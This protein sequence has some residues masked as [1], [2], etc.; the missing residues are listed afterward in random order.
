MKESSVLLRALKNEQARIETYEAIKEIRKH[1]GTDMILKLAG[2]ILTAPDDDDDDD[3]E[4]ET[5]DTNPPKKS[6]GKKV[7]VA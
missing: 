6:R 7:S 1:G 4:D 2:Y 3:D 5:M